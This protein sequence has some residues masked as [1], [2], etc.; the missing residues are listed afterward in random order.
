MIDYFFIELSSKNN[1][2]DNNL[3][4]LNLKRIFYDFL[5]IFEI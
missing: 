1:L 5:L 2:K 4:I 3:L